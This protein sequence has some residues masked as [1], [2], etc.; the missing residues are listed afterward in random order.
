MFIWIIKIASEDI[1]V[2]DF[3]NID[4]M[5][6]KSYRFPITAISSILHRITGVVLLLA[7][8]FAVMGLHYSLAGP[9][10]F[11]DVKHVLTGT[12]VSFFFW[13][14]LVAVTYHV[15]AG[16]R[17]MIMDMG[18]GETMKTA[19]ITSVLVLVLGVLSAIFWGVF[20]WL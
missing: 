11:A 10:G 18:F 12:W 14:F 13:G 8:P 5:S 3:R 7:I 2:K 1:E 15:Y 20:L 19:Q 17:H 4:L 6:I 16:V 9:N